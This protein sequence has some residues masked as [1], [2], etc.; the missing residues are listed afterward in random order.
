M[1]QTQ[2]QYDEL[3]KFLESSQAE[4]KA[5]RAEFDALKQKVPKA[6]P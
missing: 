4:I 1:R 6:A 5:L 2:K 3:R